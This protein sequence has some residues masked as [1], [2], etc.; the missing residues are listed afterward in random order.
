M[1]PKAKD[2]PSSR[3]ESDV[4]VAISTSIR[5]D[6]FSPPSRVRLRPRAVLWASMPEAAVDEYGDL[7]SNEGHIRPTTSAR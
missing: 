4:R 3:P 1:L 6:F 2:G 5:F 7:C